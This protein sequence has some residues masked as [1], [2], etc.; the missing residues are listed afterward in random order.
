MN[1]GLFGKFAAAGDDL[2]AAGGAAFHVTAGVMVPARLHIAVVAATPAGRAPVQ[3]FLSIRNYRQ[4]SA[5]REGDRF[6]LA[7]GG[8]SAHVFVAPIALSHGLYVLMF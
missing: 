5:I 3:R 2:P 1:C 4:I 7:A 8:C 6:V